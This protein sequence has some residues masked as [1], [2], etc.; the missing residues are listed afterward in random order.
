M[1]ISTGGRLRADEL[2]GMRGMAQASPDFQFER[3][4]SERER[5]FILE[6]CLD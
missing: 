4:L 1:T 5:S 2:L 6:A 3:E